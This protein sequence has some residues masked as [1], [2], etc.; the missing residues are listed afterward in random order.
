MNSNIPKYFQ[1]VHSYRGHSYGDKWFDYS[2]ELVG[3]KCGQTMIFTKIDPYLSHFDTLPSFFSPN[4][5]IVQCKYEQFYEENDELY[6]GDFP[7]L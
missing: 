6:I 5:C 3:K 7:I 4:F 2:C 1:I